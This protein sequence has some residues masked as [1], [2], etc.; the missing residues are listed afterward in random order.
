MCEREDHTTHYT[1]GTLSVIKFPHQLLLTGI[2]Q[3]SQTG[4]G[5]REDLL[6]NERDF[7]GF[8]SSHCLEEAEN[9]HTT[10]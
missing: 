10:H 9:F 3:H 2:L 6:K 7:P 1:T 5:L 4:Q 8:I